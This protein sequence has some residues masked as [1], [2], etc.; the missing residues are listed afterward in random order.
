MH[1]SS[2]LNHAT[3]RDLWGTRLASFFWQHLLLIV[4]LFIMT[5]GV[6]LCVRS[7][8]GSSV[9]SS[10]PL[11]FTLA[12]DLGM[13]PHLSIGDYTNIMNIILVAG[14]ILI[15]R[16][17]FEKMQLFQLVIGF[18]FGALL[19]VNMWLTSTLECSTIAS[20]SV[21][22]FLGCLVLGVGIAFEI[23]CG[24]VT[25]PGEGFPAAISRATGIPFPKAKIAVDI[26]L[27]LSA[28]FAGFCFFGRWMW[29]V[30]GPG[31]LFAMVFVGFVVKMLNPR[32]AWFDRVLHIQPGFHRFLFGMA[33]HIYRRRSY[34][35]SETGPASDLSDSEAEE[36][37][38]SD[39]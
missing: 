13:A 17:S 10:I 16:R 24:S 28:V 22:Q 29:E 18:L 5:F 25:M 26:A 32:L 39:M 9:I 12:G 8:L 31:T 20:K 15:L 37:P 35:S 21:T 3:D 1:S 38:G 34:G 30:I 27:V 33:R 7:N 4:S 11:A 14:Q 36:L 23:R 19:D 2:R 6:A